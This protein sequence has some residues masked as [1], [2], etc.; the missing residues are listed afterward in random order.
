MS[1]PWTAEED[2][3]LQWLMSVGAETAQI[4][5]FFGRSQAVCMR[6]RSIRN[7]GSQKEPTRRCHD[8]G[9][10]TTDYRCPRCWARLRRA[11]GYAPT[12]EASDMDTVTYGPAQ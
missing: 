12:G 11:G 6:A 8:C 7:G 4:A 2:R 9:R 1:R 3:K 10:P 5:R